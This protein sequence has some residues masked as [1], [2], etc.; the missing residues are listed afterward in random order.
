MKKSRM[1]QIGGQTPPA[2]SKVVLTTLGIQAG[3][4]LAAM[5]AVAIAANRSFRQDPWGKIEQGMN[6]FANNR[7]VQRLRKEHPQFDQIIQKLQ[8]EV[9]DNIRQLRSNN[10]HSRSGQTY[11]VASARQ[12]QPAGTAS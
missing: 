8:G 10:G 7:K 12:S 6:R 1:I 2:P 9:Q 3:I 11:D 5:G 4:G